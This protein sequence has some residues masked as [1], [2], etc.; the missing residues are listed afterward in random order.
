MSKYDKI[1]EENNAQSEC[2]QIAVNLAASGMQEIAD[3]AQRT[4]DAYQNASAILAEIDERF[5]ETTGLEKADFTI[6]M[7]ATALQIGK[8]V[9][10]GEINNSLNKSI[11]SKRVEHDDKSIKDMERDRRGEFKD[12]HENDPHVKSKH[13]DWNQLAF[14]S[15]PYDITRGS[16][17]FRVNME[18]GYHRIHTLGHDPILGW[19]FGTMNILSDTIT[20][21]D[22]HTFNVCMDH[23]NRHWELQTSLPAA[24]ADAIDSVKEDRNRLPAAVFAQALHLA[25]DK[26][27]KLGLPIPVLETFAPD[28]AGKL[29]KQGYDNLCLMKDIAVVG[30][31]AAGSAL[32]NLLITLLHGLF[33]DPKEYQSRDLFEVKTRKILL[34]SNV[35][36]SSL[37]AAAVA[38]MEV[39]AF[40]SD[41]PDL[42]KRGWAYL[43]IGGYIVTMYRLVSD[44]KFINKVKADFL[45][46]EWYNAIVGDDY[47]FISEAEQMGKKDIQKGIEI[48]ARADAAKAEKIARGLE[49]HAEVL[50]QV[51]S[52]QEGIQDTLGVVL[53]DMSEADAEKLYGLRSRKKPIELD[54]T[55]RRALCSA[56]YTLI[57]EHNQNT[58]IQKAFFFSLER[59]LGVS[60]R[61]AGFDFLNLE[62]IDSH[63]DRVAVLKVICAFSFLKDNDTHFKEQPDYAWLYEFTSTKDV[64]TICKEIEDE[65]SVL[66]CIG[67]I[68]AYH[69]ILPVSEENQSPKL[70]ANEEESDV[71]PISDDDYSTLSEIILRYTADVNSF[72][73]PANKPEETAEK[74]LR[75]QFPTFSSVSVITANKVANGYLIFSTAAIYM[76]T[77]NLLRGE[78]IRIPYGSILIEKIATSEGRTPGTRKLLITYMDDAA[79]SI[80]VDDTK[81]TEEKLRDMLIEIR[82]EQCHV[83]N[84]DISIGFEELDIGAKCILGGMLI[85]S[86]REEKKSVAPAYIYFSE[87]G[88]CSFWD[89]IANSKITADEKYS[90]F[91]RFCPYPSEKAI[92]AIAIVKML[93]ANTWSNYANKQ[94]RSL[95]SSYMES[96]IKGFDKCNLS[97]TD[98]CR[99]I[100]RAVKNVESIPID[101]IIE[102]YDDMTAS[103]MAEQADVFDGLFKIIEE[104]K[105]THPDL[106]AEVVKRADAAIQST[107]KEIKKAKGYIAAQ[108]K[109]KKQEPK[110]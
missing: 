15:V 47:Q 26:Y 66:G 4:A 89:R 78:Y 38:G 72:G 103:E 22:F 77:T 74:E 70:S 95:L 86:L 62:H 71:F 108:I 46:K 83:A 82:N 10:I 84:T 35:I 28:F 85:C 73:V 90:E 11:K 5:A 49:A 8:W 101:N 106:K 34:W 107:R 31:Q 64:D 104:Y 65:F 61:I 30:A 92:S 94:E 50:E 44:I 13:R 39:A 80:I 55:E 93:E 29:Y 75:K 88:I 45:E 17:K 41:N 6:L 36:A 1:I 57:A 7:L 54:A 100:K 98:F 37:N 33:Y 24:F 14:E 40:Y 69:G 99:M 56:I 51:K 105:I 87:N 110:E 19:I 102:L 52:Y 63:V 21:D 60:D 97:D 68:S 25:S 96:I 9:I 18:A 53:S 81:V 20:L 67:L 42:A 43:D 76:K 109:A 32:I 27:T 16:P 2:G 23:G 3:D 59:R 58:D 91:F 48:Q 79:K 12:K